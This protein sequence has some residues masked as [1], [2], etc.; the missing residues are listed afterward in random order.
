MIGVVA[1]V[2]VAPSLGLAT[3]ITAARGTAVTEALEESRGL[4]GARGTAK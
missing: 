3:F 2:L 1:P 4:V